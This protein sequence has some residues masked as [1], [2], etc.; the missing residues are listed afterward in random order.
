MSDATGWNIH[1][2]S[3]RFTTNTETKEIVCCQIT[4]KCLLMKRKVSPRGRKEAWE[5][6]GVCVC[7][8]KLHTH[9]HTALPNKPPG[10]ANP[11]RSTHTAHA[12]LR[13]PPIHPLYL[14]RLLLAFFLPPPPP[15]PPPLFFPP[16]FP[17]FPAP[18]VSFRFR[19]AG[20]D[21][22]PS[23]FFSAESCHA[24]VNESGF[25][26]R[27]APFPWRAREDL[28]PRP[29]RRTV[30][31]W[32]RSFMSPLM[33]PVVDPKAREWST[34]QTSARARTPLGGALPTA[35]RHAARYWALLRGGGETRRKG[36]GRGRGEQME[37]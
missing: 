33:S 20:F 27:P 16:F 37:K 2:D 11:N 7:V 13:P 31:S 29:R 35:A 28:P 10:K 30:W 4:L 17:P 22:R 34:R 18:P 12:S 15:P 21:F 23:R 26:F 14:L 6:A 8:C 5:R 3:L 19:A 24:F 36:E 1:Y 25:T 32:C 9:T